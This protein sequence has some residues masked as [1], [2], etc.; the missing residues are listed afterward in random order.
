MVRLR[1]EYRDSFLDIDKHPAPYSHS[2]SA[3]QL[4]LLA[5]A[6][7]GVLRLSGLR[8]RLH[9]GGQADEGRKK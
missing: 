9:G 3:G 5:L 1:K 7:A 4:L 2:D 6:L 8:Q